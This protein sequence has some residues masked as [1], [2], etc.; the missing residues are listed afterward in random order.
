MGGAK[1]EGQGV[2]DLEGG[3]QAVEDGR[4][5]GKEADGGNQIGCHSGHD[6]E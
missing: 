1:R 6:G 2:L 3:N 4:N 5:N